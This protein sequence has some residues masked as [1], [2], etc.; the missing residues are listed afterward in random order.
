MKT[1]TIERIGLS[2]GGGKGLVGRRAY[3]RVREGIR[4]GNEAERRKRYRLASR[5]ISPPRYAVIPGHPV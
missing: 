1:G 3:A 5:K 2:K 4:I